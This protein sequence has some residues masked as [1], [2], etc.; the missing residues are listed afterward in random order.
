MS[1]KPPIADRTP[2]ELWEYLC[3]ENPQFLETKRHIG[4]KQDQLKK[5]LLLA[6]GNGEQHG[7]DL[8]VHTRNLQII[9]RIKGIRAE[10]G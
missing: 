10:P 9:D 7:F 4:F 8:G 2:D 6:W 3:E 1:Q 5:L